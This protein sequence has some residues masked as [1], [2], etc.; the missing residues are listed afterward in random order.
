M[1]KERIMEKNV[2]NARLLNQKSLIDYKEDEP[3]VI[4]YTDFKN[5]KKPG[6]VCHKK[7]ILALERAVMISSASWRVGCAYW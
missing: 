6:K 7:V 5:F 3:V 4:V 1:R 2:L